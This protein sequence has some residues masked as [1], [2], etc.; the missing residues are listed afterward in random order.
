MR[1]V[2]APTE[3]YMFTTVGGTVRHAVTYVYIFKA[4]KEGAFTLPSFHLEFEQ[5]TYDY[6]SPTIPIIAASSDNSG[7]VGQ[8]KENTFIRI[9]VSAKEA[10]VGDRIT[11]VL[12]F[13]GRDRVFGV[14]D[15]KVP[16]FDG[17]LVEKDST[18]QELEMY[19]E[20]INGK[21]FNTFEIKEYESVPLYAG[22]MAIGECAMDVRMA[23]EKKGAYL[24]IFL[25]KMKRRQQ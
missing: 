17:F 22:D 7:L 24:M 2:A 12:K 16:E 25:G 3:N 8:D 4:T 14:E 13:Y 18:F 1:Q 10:N 6:T 15:F 19:S 21:R 11:A 9:E 20:F 5:K 23:P